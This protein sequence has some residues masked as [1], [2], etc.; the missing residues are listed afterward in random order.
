MVRLSRGARCSPYI[1]KCVCVSSFFSL[2]LLDSLLFASSLSI[3]SRAAL[4][5]SFVRRLHHPSPSFEEGNEN[6]N[7]STPTDN[8]TPN[9]A[10]MH[11]AS[12]SRSERT[13]VG[14]HIQFVSNSAA[15]F[16]F[17]RPIIEMTPLPS[18]VVEECYPIDKEE[19]EQD[20]QNEKVSRETAQNQAVLAMW[21]G[22]FDSI[23]S[24]DG[25][26]EEIATGAGGEC[27]GRRRGTPKQR[28]RGK[29]AGRR[30]RRESSIFS[31]ER[32]SLLDS[33]RYE[34]FSSHGRGGDESTRNNNESIDSLPLSVTINPKKYASP[35]SV[36]TEI[37]GSAASSS[38]DDTANY[39]TSTLGTPTDLANARESL[40]STSSAHVSP[41]VPG[42]SCL[43]LQ[44]R[45]LEA[46]TAESSNQQLGGEHPPVHGRLPRPFSRTCTNPVRRIHPREGRRE[47]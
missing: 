40:D 34:T 37:V 25:S 14:G 1:R 20:V 13:G 12:S 42:L 43:R 4:T 17:E 11:I 26:D 32:R 24:G 22:H 15:E 19:T 29:M 6:S 10:G 18:A 21:D 39:S 38:D 33:D 35:F 3:K 27:H 47:G 16:H 45:I 46:V 44:R 31:Q 7:L 5:P 41:E 8:V 28:R 36:P 9:V 2:T 23:V 30:R